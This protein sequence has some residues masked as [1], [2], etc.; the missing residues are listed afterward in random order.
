MTCEHDDNFKAGGCQPGFKIDKGHRD[1]MSEFSAEERARE[2]AKWFFQ[3]DDP[4]Q[5]ECTR[6]VAAALVAYGEEQQRIVLEQNEV[7]V[8]VRL[9]AREQ[10]GYRRG[11]EEAA[12][13]V[14]NSEGSL[15]AIGLA[16]RIM[17]LAGNRG[18]K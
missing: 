18:S 8:Q 17:A 6:R 15:G 12:G 16:E 4:Q 3:V 13:M 11:I 9:I 10:T 1:G 2:I 14:R 5:D 7:L